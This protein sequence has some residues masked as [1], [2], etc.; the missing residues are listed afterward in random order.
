MEVIIKD[1]PEDCARAGG[2]IIAKA[3]KKK[4]NYVL[5]FATGSTPVPLYEDLISRYEAGE[6]D[7]SAAASFNLDEYIGLA[8]DHPCSYRR[9]MQEKLFDK[10]NLRPENTNIPNGLA[11][12]I[13]AEC[14]SYELAIRAVGGIDLQILGIGTDGHI[15]FNEP[16][17]SLGS[18]TRIKTLTAKTREDN[19]RFFESL[20]DVPRHCI[21]M[22][23][24]TIMECERLLLFAFGEGKAEIIAKAVEGPVTAMVPASA[25]QLHRDVKIILDEPAASAL[26]LRD[27]YKEVFEFK[28]DWQ[29]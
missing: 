20:P 24:G 5:G 26:K 1:T 29:R 6:I 15:A 8:P 21:T 22:G 19:A 11:Q 23:V 2:G 16:G 17:S 7:F 14:L 3:M 28:P 10:V 9:F 12:D 25:L 13:K 27:Y 18:R 4:P